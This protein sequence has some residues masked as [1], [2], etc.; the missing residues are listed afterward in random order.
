MESR[1]RILIVED[2]RSCE[3]ILKQIIHS[4]DPGAQVDWVESGEV[5]ALTL[6]QERSKGAPYSLVISDI[7]LSGKLTGIDVWKI[8]S[9]F[10]PLPPVVLTSSIPIPKYFE[11]VGR[12][13]DVPIY[14]PKPFYAEECRQI[15]R[16]FMANV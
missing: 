10:S 9:E 2:D 8:Y 14:L 13:P 12:G 16:R 1:N 6:V 5:A 3:T 15:I 4:V 11:A 7:A